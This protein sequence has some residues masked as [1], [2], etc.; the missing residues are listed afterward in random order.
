MNLL[1]RITQ[2]AGP[3]VAATIQAEFGGMC[4][5]INIDRMPGS[6]A[7]VQAPHRF[8][9]TIEINTLALQV[10]RQLDGQP[11]AVVREV[12]D[13]AAGLAVSYT[14]FEL[15]LPWFQQAIAAHQAL[16]D[17]SAQRPGARS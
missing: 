13:A 8:P 11:V 9:E 14:R 12:C 6:A 4:P 3:A 7:V 17:E 16:C 5:Y 1:D 2:L 10:L 15:N